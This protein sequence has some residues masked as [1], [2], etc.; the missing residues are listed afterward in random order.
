LFRGHTTLDEGASFL[1]AHAYSY[2]LQ[3]RQPSAAVKVGPT[4]VSED[5]QGI[6]EKAKPVS[7]RSRRLETLSVM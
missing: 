3:R 6:I 2:K 1:D 4:G 7:T 5:F